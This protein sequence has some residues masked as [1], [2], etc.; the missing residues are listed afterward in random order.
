MHLGSFSFCSI[1]F[2]LFQF[3]VCTTWC[4]CPCSRADLSTISTIKV[5]RH[6]SPVERGGRMQILQTEPHI[7]GFFSEKILLPLIISQ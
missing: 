3:I 7:S 5:V 4:V 2:K 1:F 6:M